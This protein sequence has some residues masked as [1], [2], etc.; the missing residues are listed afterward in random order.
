MLRRL[1]AQHIAKLSAELVGMYALAATD[2][3][4]ADTLGAERLRLAIAIWE[5]KIAIW[6]ALLPGHGKEKSHE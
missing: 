6:L 1:V 4:S 3:Y 2:L 5:L